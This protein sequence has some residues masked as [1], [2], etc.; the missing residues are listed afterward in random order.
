MAKKRGRG[1][2]PE[3]TQTA[4]VDAAFDSLRHDG[5]GA[6]TARAIA[7][8]AD[9]NQAAIYYHFG[10]IDALLVEALRRSSNRRLALYQE[11]IGEV[12]DLGALIDTIQELYRADRESGHLEV[13]TELVGGLTSS[14]ELKQGIADVTAPWLEFVEAKTREAASTGTPLAGA[15][16]AEDVTNMLFSLVLGLEM[17]SKIDGDFERADRMFRLAR[18]AAGLL[19]AIT[20]KS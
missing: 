18:L 7:A 6:T 16:P 1:A 11:T 13:L 4:L 12:T 15:L 3:Q 2:D 14:P 19:P 10:G 17:R 8:R 20:K 9:C 5:L